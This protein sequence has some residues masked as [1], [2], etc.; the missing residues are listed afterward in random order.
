MLKKLNNEE[1]LALLR[2]IEEE[3]KRL[4]HN[5]SSELETLIYDEDEIIRSKAILHLWNYPTKNFLDLLIKY[6]ISDNSLTVRTNAIITLGRYVYEDAINIF[7]IDLNDYIFPENLKGEDFK[8]VIQFLLNIFN[9]PD[10]SCNERCAA[11]EALSYSTD[12]EVAIV[13]SKAF[14][15]NDISLKKS[16]IYA[17]GRNKAEHW[18]IILLNEFNKNDSNLQKPLI[19]AA[20]EYKLY[21]AG[22]FLLKLAHSADKE[23]V[24]ETI[25]ALSKIKYK[26]AYEVID[27]LSK[28]TDHDIQKTAIDA[29]ECWHSDNIIHDY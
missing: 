6:A 9:D 8:N 16:A 27:K 29:L 26:A 20:G 23:L 3:E 18:K 21:E 11:L 17:M 22:P 25:K 4:F 14:Q 1:K 24:K 13:I 28:N 19:K 10:K 15:D 2:I 7:D 12:Q 5:Y